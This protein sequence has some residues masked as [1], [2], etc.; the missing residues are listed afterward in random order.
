MS[1]IL[2]RAVAKGLSSTP[3][4]FQ[5]Q[6]R[7]DGDRADEEDDRAG[8]R[9]TDR[10]E[11]GGARASASPAVMPMSSVPE[12]AKLTV[13]IVVNTAPKLIIMR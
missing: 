8:R 11:D 13:R 1:R 2:D 6:R 10:A 3:A 4:S 9:R 12:K 5:G 7:D